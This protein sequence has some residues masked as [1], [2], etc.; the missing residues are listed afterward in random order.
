MVQKETNLLVFLA[1]KEKENFCDYTVKV[2]SEQ[3]CKIYIRDSSTEVA[4]VY[5][6]F[7]FFFFFFFLN[8]L[9]QLS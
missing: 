1:N 9:Y 5:F 8:N 4:K 6:S 2:G 7:L 3:S